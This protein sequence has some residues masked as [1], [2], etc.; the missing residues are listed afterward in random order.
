MNFYCLKNPGIAIHGLRYWQ[1]PDVSDG[2]DSGCFSAIEQ[3]TFE[4]A[5]FGDHTSLFDSDGDGLSDEFEISEGMDPASAAVCELEGLVCLCGI[6]NH[7][8]ENSLAKKAANACKKYG[9]GNNNA[10]ANILEAFINEVEAQGGI[11]IPP[12]V[13]EMLIDYAMAAC[14]SLQ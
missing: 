6:E 8:I 5:L 3:V 2:D 10:A 7:G 1:D 12:S 9:Q 4:G 11:H 13:A 14:Q